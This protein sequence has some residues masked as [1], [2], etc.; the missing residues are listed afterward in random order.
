MLI[1]GEVAQLIKGLLCKNE[2]PGYHIKPEV[3]IQTSNP[4]VKI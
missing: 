1:T 2:D 3:V 4:C